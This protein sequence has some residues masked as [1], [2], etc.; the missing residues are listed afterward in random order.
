MAVEIIPGFSAT[1]TSLV[2]DE[3]NAVQAVRGQQAS[4]QDLGF[5]TA[6][7]GGMSYDD[8]VAYLQ[9]ELATEKA[10]PLVSADR[11][12]QIQ[13]QLTTTQASAR[14]QDYETAYKS[15]LAE[16]AAGKM[17]AQQNL[18]FLNT[19][20]GMTSD[21]ALKSEIQTNI[22][23][24]SADVFAYNTTIL[25]NDQQHAVTSKSASLLTGAIAETQSHMAT[26]TMNG[27]QVAAT[28][29]AAA[30]A[31]LQS[32]LG[33]VTIQNSLNDAAVKSLTKGTGAADKLSFLNGQIQN[34]DSTI[35]VTVGGQ[36]Y[37]SSQAYWTQLKASYL[38]GNNSTFA[39]SQ[40][41]FGVFSSFFAEQTKAMQA[42]IDSSVKS[43][44]Y[45]TSAVIDNLQSQFKQ[46]SADPDVAAYTPQLQTLQDT[47]IGGA[48]QNMASA[49]VDFAK[50]DTT[51]TGS[52][53]VDFSNADVALNNLAT[54]YGVN[55]DAYRLQNQVNTKAF[56]D[57]S[58]TDQNVPTTS[59]S[60][61]T[62]DVK[63]PVVEP[64]SPTLD[65]G[66]SSNPLK[67]LDGTQ[68]S[69]PA[70]T[71]P[72]ETTPTETQIAASGTHTVAAGDTLS[73]IAAKNGTTVAALMSANPD[74][75]NANQIAVGQQIKLPT[76]PIAPAPVAPTA[77][78][79]ITPA[80]PVVAPK[81]PAVVAPAAPVVPTVK[82]PAPVPPAPVA[83]VVPPTENMAPVASTVV[84]PQVQSYKI[85]SGDTLSA[86]AA[87]SGT[88][89]NA[90]MA[91]NPS[92]TNANM[93]NAGATISIPTK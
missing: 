4:E 33:T 45:V 47:I 31:N 32:N 20:L 10:S 70:E 19:Q 11:V 5:Q 6:I 29:D 85:A 30:I 74:I 3:L 78:L 7:A 25:Q 83:T 72:T 77:A 67:K 65:T 93:I 2:N 43:N 28:A 46:F 55:L 13:S 34:G 64:P 71:T 39:T 26:M 82:P 69:P 58:N 18:D 76:T 80:T 61:A 24:A 23:S 42:Q 36:D 50:G 91:A 44:G 21:P 60:E 17:T 49:V 37:A 81:A 12:A 53:G 51:S 63:A 40:N 48:V 92:I 90:I 1:I 9:N 54:K 8:Q 14:A 27:D 15:N 59:A 22:D 35:P 84:A 68:I 16:V 66:D 52:N 73:A 75:T 38:A 57:S 41:D 79:P 86:I 89:V 88:T 62:P 87:K 56:M